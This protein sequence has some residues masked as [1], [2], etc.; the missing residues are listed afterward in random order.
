MVKPLKFRAETRWQTVS[1][2]VAQP[3]ASLNRF[4]HIKLQSSIFFKHCRSD[5][6]YLERNN[7]GKGLIVCV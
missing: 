5:N 3:S 6:G 2:E 4:S 1:R 7:C